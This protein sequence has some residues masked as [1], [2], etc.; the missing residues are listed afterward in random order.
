MELKNRLLFE[1]WSS[2]F[3]A[4][5]VLIPFMLA[6]FFILLFV[7]WLF[8]PGEYTIITNAISDL[9]SRILNPRGWILFSL[10]FVFSSITITPIIINL[11]ERVKNLNLV[12]SWIATCAAS[13]STVSFLFLAIFPKELTNLHNIAA[14]C[15]FLGLII[16]STFYWILMIKLAIYKIKIRHY[17]VIINISIVVSM[18]IITYWSFSGQFI[19]A[20]YHGG[21]LN[22][23]WEW[24][25][26][27]VICAQ[28]LIISLLAPERLVKKYPLIKIL[29]KSKRSGFLVKLYYFGK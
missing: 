7:S 19:Y 14:L 24:I 3:F 26:L 28:L 18:V 15:S 12:F 22:P 27:F 2:K 8:Y 21:R 17:K 13:L 9:G 23:L 11:H 16:G 10:A 20:Y 1:K 5:V 25:L 6:G 29:P 4:S